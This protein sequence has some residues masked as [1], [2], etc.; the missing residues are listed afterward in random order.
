MQPTYPIT[1]LLGSPLKTKRACLFPPLV[2]E[3]LGQV[4]VGDAAVDSRGGDVELGG[5]GDGVE[6]EFAEL[7]VAP[8]F[9]DVASGEAEGA[10]AVRTFDDPQASIS[11][12]PWASTMCR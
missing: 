7:G 5:P 1:E 3:V 6:D 12:R 8:V 11:S 10:A 2:V 9:V 4:V